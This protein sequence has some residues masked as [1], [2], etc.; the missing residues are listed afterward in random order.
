MHETYKREPAYMYTLLK[1]ANNLSS[2]FIQ[3]Y[4]QYVCV[5]A[6]HPAVEISL[7]S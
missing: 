7:I 5:I 4:K 3:W 2:L 1:T 6:H